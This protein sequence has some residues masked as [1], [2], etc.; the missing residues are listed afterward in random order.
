MD[1]RKYIMT[2]LDNALT[3]LEVMA[4]HRDATLTELRDYTGYSRSSL[5]KMLYT[6]SSR[7]FV[8]KTDDLRYSLSTK[9]MHLG[10]SVLTSIDLHSVAA[11]HIKKLCAD[12]NETIHMAVPTDDLKSVMFLIKERCDRPSAQMNLRMDSSVGRILPAHCTSLGKSVLSLLPDSEIDGLYIDYDF[13]YFSNKSILTTE[14]LKTCLS[15]VRQRGYALD[16]EEFEE[17]LYCIG[18]PIL[19]S[20][21]HGVAAIS[22]S[23]PRSRIFASE[24]KYSEELKKAAAAISAELGYR[25]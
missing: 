9:F 15:E 8:S 11:S 14:A 12:L 23:G 21:G 7:G 3:L 25:S 16:D 22:V 10:N 5:F 13:P 6:L 1:D 20:S 19:D 18:S 2:S 17:G 24:A 4:D